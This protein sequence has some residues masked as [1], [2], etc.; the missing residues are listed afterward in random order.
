MR[1]PPLRTAWRRWL[2]AVGA[3]AL[4]FAGGFGIY[5][6]LVREGVLRYNQWDRRERGRLKKGDAAPDLVLASYGSG[7]VRLSE[8]WRERP[9]VL[10]FGSC[11]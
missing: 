4:L 1:L 8:L 3:A 7:T 5:Y 10:V 6:V 9:V 2:A 11:T